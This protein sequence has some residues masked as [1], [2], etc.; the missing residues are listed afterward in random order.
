MEMLLRMVTVKKGLKE[1]KK[2]DITKRSK[3][4][5]DMIFESGDGTGDVDS[6]D[7]EVG[8]DGVDGVDGVAGKDNIKGLEGTTCV[9]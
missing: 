8:E 2:R 6:E 5:K 4:P 7:G 1:S 3:N 9:C